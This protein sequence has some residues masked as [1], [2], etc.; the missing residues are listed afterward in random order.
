MIEA[1]T[2]TEVADLDACKCPDCGSESFLE[3]PHGGMS[4][5]IMCSACGAKFNVVP[6][7]FGSFGKQRIGRPDAK[8]Q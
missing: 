4:V 2:G 8:K 6:G 5:N 3:G 1:L 7:I